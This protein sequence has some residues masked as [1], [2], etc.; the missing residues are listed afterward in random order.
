M[1]ISGFRLGVVEIFD[2]SGCFASSSYLPT[3]PE[4][5][6]V[7]SSRIKQSDLCDP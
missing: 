5:V 1:E 2:V 4:N 6:L 7:L 3:F